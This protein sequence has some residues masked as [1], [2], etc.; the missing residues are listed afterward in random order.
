MECSQSYISGRLVVREM[1]VVV[2]NMLVVVKDMLQCSQRCV[3]M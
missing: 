1:L 2:R 3:Y